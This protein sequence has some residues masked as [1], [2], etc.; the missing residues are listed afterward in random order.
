MCLDDERVEHG[1]H[2]KRVPCCPAQVNIVLMTKIT[3]HQTHTFGNHQR[4]F[5]QIF[6]RA[7]GP[8]DETRT[9]TLYLQ[10]SQTIL[11]QHKE[12]LNAAPLQP[13]ALPL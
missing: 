13:I 12:L 10:E 11:N 1:N 9:G 6:K 3:C 7:Q 4:I 2:T 5:S 8:G